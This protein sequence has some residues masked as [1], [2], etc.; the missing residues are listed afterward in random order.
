M[1]MGTNYITNRPPGIADVQCSRLIFQPGYRIIVRTRGKLDAGQR[2][3]L[4]KSVQKFA[5]CEVEVLIINVF[6][7]ELEIQKGMAGMPCP[8][9]GRTTT[10]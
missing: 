1:L 7:M 4:R 6:D 10:P 2:R 9:C 3:K 5:G 8:M